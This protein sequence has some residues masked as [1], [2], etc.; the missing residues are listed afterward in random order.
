MTAQSTDY[1]YI[2]EMRALLPPEWRTALDDTW[3]YGSHPE[4]PM[5]IQGWKFHIS[6]RLG[7][8][9]IATL[10]S[11]LTVCIE[12]KVNFKAARSP[13]IHER[14]NSK[15]TRREASNKFLTLYPNP[16]APDPDLLSR[17]V[18]DLNAV[19]TAD[20]PI[21]HSDLQIG[22]QSHTRYGAHRGVSVLQPDGTS[23]IRISDPRDGTLIPDPR[24]P[25][26]SPPAWINTHPITGKPLD[27]DD[28]SDSDIY[29]L[30]EFT[31][32]DALHFSATGGVY[33]GSKAATGEPV[34][35]KEGIPNA[36]YIQQDDQDAVD[37][38]VAEYRMLE[39]L[40]VTGV[41]PKPVSI[42]DY[43][44]HTFIA[45]EYIDAPTLS[46]TAP[47][48]FGDA[49]AIATLLADA[50]AAIHRSGVVL[51]DLSAR[52]VLLPKRG[53]VKI[54]DLE[55]AYFTSAPPEIVFATPGY[56]PAARVKGTADDIYS[57]GAVLTHLFL[58]R[59][60]GLYDLAADPADVAQ[61]FCR[62]AGMPPSLIKLITECLSADAQERPS[63]AA[64][65]D[66]LSS[67]QGRVLS[68]QGVPT[69]VSSMDTE[70]GVEM[71]IDQTINPL[72]ECLAADAEAGQERK[73]EGRRLGIAEGIA[74]QTLALQYLTAG[75]ESDGAPTPLVERLNAGRLQL[76]EADLDG[77]I[78]P[79]GLANGLAGIA[80]AVH[81]TT[82]A[83]GYAE[84][85][86]SRALAHPM[87]EDPNF[88][89]TLMHGV[90]GIGLTALYFYKQSGDSAFLDGA[91]WCAE[92]LK[93][94]VAS[95][96]VASNAVFYFAV[97]D[98]LGETVDAKRWC[99]R[100]RDCLNAL[101]KAPSSKTKKG[102][103]AHL[104][105]VAVRQAKRAFGDADWSAFAMPAWD[106]SKAFIADPSL[107]SGLSGLGLA[108]LDH[109]HYGETGESI[110]LGTALK[111]A[112][113]VG[114]FTCR[115]RN[116]KGIVFPGADLRGADFGLFG[117]TA[118]AL[119][120][121]ERLRQ[122]PLPPA[123]FFPWEWLCVDSHDFR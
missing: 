13:S 7:L 40:A 112:K 100:G 74:G 88:P 99:L 5:A 52:N 86:M 23:D 32:I 70:A 46:E 119:V 82:D 11:A 106:F 79:P 63:A 110:H 15:Q 73:T 56:A 25:F 49:L 64:V 59:I 90:T 95:E 94:A 55:G 9:A 97:A 75:A 117:G 118:G 51:G 71:D 84:T 77:A 29:T 31:V 36:M 27:D 24:G 62:F 17:L 80:Y 14:L 35:L 121:L 2:S 47:L 20:A 66:H 1:I 61:R 10:R 122:Q 92:R 60:N 58:G 91:V 108:Y 116:G 34:V 43:E 105:E 83:T 50:I 89:V 96:Q 78:L 98:A 19:L 123:P 48:A 8:P 115:S 85:L 4:T 3:F 107:G 68:L 103:N 38:L 22:K 104:L 87:L 6:S 81:R 30:N 39:H 26:F 42:F 120:F 37:R 109:Y 93:D 114:C 28:D 33:R 67:L 101:A 57:L 65:A 54:I 76:L 45:M 53:G 111:I 12:Q 102:I 72:V 21:V 41:T 69:G 18:Q 44:S 16:E 113:T